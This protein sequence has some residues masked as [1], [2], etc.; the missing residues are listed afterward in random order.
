MNISKYVAEL[1]FDF[2]CVVIPGFGGLIVNDKPS[3]VNRINHQFKPPFRN[4]LFNTHL[5]AN[6]GLLVNQ[7]AASEGISFKEARSKVDQFVLSVVEQLKNGG[8]FTFENIGTIHYDKEEN[9]VFEQNNQVNYNPHSYGL[10]GFVSPPVKRISDEEKLRNIIIPPKA[11]TTKPVDRKPDIV[12]EKGEKKR[13]YRAVFLVLGILILLLSFGWGITNP[14]K[15]RFYWENTASAIAY[16]SPDFVQSSK[17]NVVNEAR[18]IPRKMIESDKEI[19][20]RIEKSK[21]IAEHQPVENDLDTE[22]Q[23][24]KNIIE[25]VI[26]QPKEEAVEDIV[27]NPP[28][29]EPSGPL[30]YIIAGSF[31]NVKNAE[32]LVSNLKLKGFNAQIADTN[33]TGMFRVAYTGIKKLSE[34][35]EKLYAIRQD[36]NPDAWL[37]RK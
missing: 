18:Y 15:V 1:L 2:E 32:R 23:P 37:I 9:I 12:E 7:I 24:I 29:V 16:I 19:L 27:I 20:A 25:E 21:K 4:I 36:D 14:D 8:S 3:T 35:K 10:T 13:K 17:Q 11:K 5:K 34:A 33:S 28:K 31:S 22:P 30:Y 6:D 26:P